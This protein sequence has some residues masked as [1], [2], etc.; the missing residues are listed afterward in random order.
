MDVVNELP[1]DLAK[2][3]AALDARA[4]TMA[5][6]VDASRVAARVTERL[7]AESAPAP[8]RGWTVVRIAAA[9]AILAAGAVAT[10]AVLRQ[11]RPAAVAALPVEVP[12]SVSEQQAAA[13]LD[14]MATGAD[15]ATATAA[16]ITVDDL[17]EAEL[18]ALLQTMQSEEGSL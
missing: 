13:A 8:R 10:R 9:L 4:A 18:Q 2:A 1:D 5:A 6:R 3:L 7:R 17:N 16:V 12:D 15:S 11:E 14:A